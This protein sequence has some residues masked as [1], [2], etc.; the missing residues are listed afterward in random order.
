MLHF[1]SGLSH[2]SLEE[3]DCTYQDRQYRVSAVIRYKTHPDHFVAY[4]RDTQ[5]MDCLMVISRLVTGL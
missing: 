3:L 1:V 4:I 2:N 5:G